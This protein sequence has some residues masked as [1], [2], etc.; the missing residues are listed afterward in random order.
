MKITII[1]VVTILEFYTLYIII[2]ATK[3]PVIADVM[4]T[5]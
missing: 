2:L 5:H 3:N 4:P 1:V